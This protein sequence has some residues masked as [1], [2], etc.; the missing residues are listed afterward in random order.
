MRANYGEPEAA[1]AHFRRAIALKRPRAPMAN[2]LA[3]T[4]TAHFAA[5]RHA[6]AASW[7]RR[8]MAENPGAVGL[9]RVLAPYYL[10]L[11]KRAAARASL[12]RLRRAYPAIT[13]KV[14]M[15]HLPRIRA[16][17]AM[18]DDGPIPDGLAALGLPPGPSPYGF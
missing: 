2:C 9:N 8:A 11:G 4:A 16:G 14:V 1:L 15:L 3:G 13:V 5:G 18:G 10:A 17:R 7:L 12:G 6:E